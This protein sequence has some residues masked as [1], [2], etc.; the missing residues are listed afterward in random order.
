MSDA[1]IQVKGLKNQFGSHVVHDNLDLTIQRGDIT[2]IVGGSGSGK[3]VLMRSIIGLQRPVAGTIEMLG[4]TVG[5][6]GIQRGSLLSR[7]MGVLFQSGALLSSLTVLENI[8]MPLLEHTDIAKSD[9]LRLAKTK[10]ALVGLPAHA[11]GLFPSELSGGMV[12]RA[13]LAR[14]LAL[15]PELLFLDEPTAG[16]DPISAAAFDDLLVT[17]RNALGFTVFLVTHDLDT[18]YHS[19]DRVAVIAEKRI[20][21]HDTL[22]QVAA[23]DHPWLKDYFHG[24][25]GRAAASISRQNKER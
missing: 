13:A 19:C 21:I 3:S 5:P 8:A 18:L 15:E 1:V 9:A 24:P 6:N 17:L 16:L 25:R 14:A 10:L 4:E 22:E 23:F 7:K 20:I 2:G 12:K 11:A